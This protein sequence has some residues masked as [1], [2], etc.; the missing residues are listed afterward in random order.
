MGKT[1]HTTNPGK[2]RAQSP[3]MEK[4]DRFPLINISVFLSA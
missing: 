2:L 1:H 4:I 3:D